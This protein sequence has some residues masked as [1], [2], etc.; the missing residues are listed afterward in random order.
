MKEF[1][2]YLNSLWLKK[3]KLGFSLHERIQI[4]IG[5]VFELSTVC[6]RH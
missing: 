2:L 5:V 6:E 4:A 3:Y 1:K